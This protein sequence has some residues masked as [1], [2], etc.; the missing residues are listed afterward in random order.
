M[1]REGAV[2]DDAADGT[3]PI[4]VDAIESAIHCIDRKQAQAVVEE[5]GR[6]VSEHD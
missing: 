1:G 4:L 2:E 6:H 5:M 3:R